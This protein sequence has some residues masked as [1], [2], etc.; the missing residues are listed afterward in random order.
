LFLCGRGR[1][2]DHSQGCLG[3][4]CLGDKALEVVAVA[5]QLLVGFQEHAAGE[6][7]DVDQRRVR[8]RKLHQQVGAG[9]AEMCSGTERDAWWARRAGRVGAPDRVFR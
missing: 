2:F 3:A 1:V 6:V 7:L 8:L 5:V 9:H 4:E